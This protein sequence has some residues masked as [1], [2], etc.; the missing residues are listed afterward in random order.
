LLSGLLV[1]L[2]VCLFTP[3]AA[4]Q[5]VQLDGFDPK[6]IEIDGNVTFEGTPASQVPS[7]GC[8]SGFTDWANL[9]NLATNH[10]IHDSCCNGDLSIVGP[11]DVLK[12]GSML[13]KEDI[14]DVYV[15]SNA[16]YL[17]T[18]ETRRANNGNSTYHWLFT[19]VEPDVVPGQT[20]MFHL[21]NG[22]IE[23]RVCFPSTNVPGTMEVRQV[24]GLSGQVNAS[25][26]NIWNALGSHLVLNAGAVAGFKINPAPTTALP[27]A[28][29][30]K[31]NPTNTYDTA[32]FAEGAV[33]LAQ[34]GIVPCGALAYATVV[35]RSSCSLTSAVKD[36][37]GPNVYRFGGCTVKLDSTTIGCTEAGGAPVSI[38]VHGESGSGSYTWT[39]PAGWSHTETG[40]SSTGTKTLAASE[41]ITIQVCDAAV[42][43]CCAHVDVPISLATQVAVSLGAPEILCTGNT[44][45]HVTLSAT[46]SG[47]DGNFTYKWYDNDNLIAGQTG[48]QL[49]TTLAVGDHTIKVEVC[50]NIPGVSDAPCCASDQ[51]TF[52]IWPKLT[53][54]LDKPVIGCTGASSAPVTITATASGGDGNYSYQ[55]KDNGVT[56][57]GQTGNKLTDYPFSPGDHT[58]QVTVSD[59]ISGISGPCT[60]QASVNF[61]VNDQ[62]A[63][64]INAPS[65]HCEVD[66]I[67]ITTLTAVA[68]GGAGN[69]QFT[70]YD[71]TGPL[72]PQIGTGNPLDALLSAGSHTVRVVVTS[73]YTDPAGNV[74]QCSAEN[75]RTFDV[76]QPL[77]L[78]LEVF[79]GFDA[80]ISGSPVTLRASASGGV[81]PY[82]YTWSVDGVD[83]KTETPSDAIP[84]FYTVTFDDTNLCTSKKVEVRVV[85][86]DNCTNLP[87]NPSKTVTKTTDLT[88]TPP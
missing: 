63:V 7:A 74:H 76:P 58:V 55:W 40:N 30:S 43:D 59:S 60:A 84:S 61:H 68:T 73:D 62:L 86:A 17:Y 49:D 31:G 52:K 3:P 35:T 82:T 21:N 9:A 39:W 29:D 72:A 71:G 79:D 8:V 24:Q 81:A 47:G 28:I 20:I 2:A 6:C 11:Q 42:P 27:G 41:T 19:Q 36:I 54:S 51:K 75:T 65:F 50:D 33:S 70:W 46:A 4:A 10:T 80:C 16:T 37:A 48:S 13:P 18:A 34:L 45:G 15:S 64:S 14:T 85:D 77:T 57:P 67:I 78:T 26:S 5:L 32:T 38:T 25:V 1:V 23:I 88:V 69:Y 66:G 12:G 87:P 53:V 83:V 56:I 22:D 44:G